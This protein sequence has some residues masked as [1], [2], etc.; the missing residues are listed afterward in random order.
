MRFRV[1]RN[2][3]AD[4]VVWTARALP[5]RPAVPI[6]AGMRLEATEQLRLSSFDYEVSAEASLD[7]VDVEE[8]G[9]AL[10]SGR[11]LAEITRSLPAQPVQIA[12]DGAKAT[13]TCGNAK[14]TLM[15]LPVEEYPTLPEMPPPSG[16]IG[17]DSLAT[18]VSQ[19]A[20]AA[21]RDDTLPLLTGVLL[22]IEG[23]T[24]SLSASSVPDR[25][26]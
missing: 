11:L 14:F 16:T 8:T 25:R 6:L 9:S 13:L 4:A 5:T 17:S 19:V 24:I 10:M 26:P 23:D 2:M 3:L 1:D 18:A 22:E 21:S 15:T 12:T 20:V 7:L